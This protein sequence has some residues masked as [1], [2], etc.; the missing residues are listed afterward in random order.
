VKKVEL[1]RWGKYF[2]ARNS[3]LGVEAAARRARLGVSS[4]YRFERGD[5]GSSGGLVAA[6]ELGVV[7]VGGVLVDAPLCEEARRALEDFAFFR[8]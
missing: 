7:Q 6:A 8:L 1:V 2:D 3:G 5:Q 4:A